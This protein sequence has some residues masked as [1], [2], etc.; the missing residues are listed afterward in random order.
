MRLIASIQGWFYK[1][2][3]VDWSNFKVLEKN[4]SKL[5]NISITV[6]CYNPCLQLRSKSC[7]F[8]K[9]YLQSD[10][11]FVCSDLRQISYCEEAK[12]ESKLKIKHKLLWRWMKSQTKEKSFKYV[13]ELKEMTIASPSI[14]TSFFMFN[15]IFQVVDQRRCHLISD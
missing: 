7:F 4:R 5:L 15:F 12:E 14:S 1:N 10:E 6:S 11:N 13:F 8:H 3:S 2:V 9:F